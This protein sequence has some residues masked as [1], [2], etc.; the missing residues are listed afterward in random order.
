ME[1]RAG[2]QTK[3]ST[4]PCDRCSSL[5]TEQRPLF[6]GMYTHCFACDGAKQ[7]P[8]VRVEVH[9][10]KVDPVVTARISPVR[11][12]FFPN[13]G[14]QPSVGDLQSIAYY[15]CYRTEAEAGAYPNFRPVYEVEFD[16]DTPNWSQ[17]SGAP[18]ARFWH[19]GDPKGKIVR[20][21]P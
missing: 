21:I 18:G 7:T 16:F 19:R 10:T 2:Y 9:R 17:G 6:V 11:T 12:C 13:Q 5:R 1:R 4:K 15:S 20:V 8:A 14:G 3:P